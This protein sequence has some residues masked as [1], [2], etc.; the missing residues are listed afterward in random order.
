MPC[1]RSFAP[2][3]AFGLMF[4]L[5]G[6]SNGSPGAGIPSIGFHAQTRNAIKT[7]SA[8][9]KLVITG[10]PSVIAT[11]DGPKGLWTALPSGQT[12]FQISGT[13]YGVA[14][15][16]GSNNPEDADVYVFQG[17]IS[18]LKSVP[19]V[20]G[21][22]NGGTENF[23]VSFAPSSFCPNPH[24]VFA[25]YVGIDGIGF[26]D[27]TSC[28]GS[29][30]MF[31]AGPYFAETQDF[32]GVAADGEG[33]LMAVHLDPNVA[34]P[35]S[36]SIEFSGADAIGPDATVQY[37][38]VPA[39][40]QPFGL[41]V[42]FGSFEWWQLTL[43][44]TNSQTS[45]NYPTIAGGDV[46]KND[47][48]FAWSEAGVT[49]HGNADFLFAGAF[50]PNPPSVLTYQSPFNAQVTPAGSPQF[51]LNYFGYSKLKGGKTFYAIM[52]KWSTQNAI[53]IVT[54]AFLTAAGSTTYTFPNVTVSG[55]PPMVAQSN[56]TYTW[57]ASAV[58]APHAY[59]AILP[60]YQ[61]LVGE[62]NF[63]E[64]PSRPIDGV[65]PGVLDVA[66]A[67]NS[68]NVP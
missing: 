8:T 54:P 61:L 53:T 60:F 56:T 65:P 59:L 13:A 36:T 4:V 14:Y 40:V 63:N 2:V 1:P 30:Q 41:F 21:Q 49:G 17:T 48:Y 68:F 67:N 64:F 62:G 55:F 7:P 5:G 25:A 18:D 45:L 51:K 38:N 16:C 42:Q 20:C 9:V 66:S 29:P 58:H 34:V 52:G 46:G 43:G 3:T 10:V 12:S 28:G 22:F 50:S 11:Q 44:S 15:V 6:C 57:W 24:G 19:V 47:S 31:S 26:I 37:K 27:A 39:G 35:G 33:N 32:F 23:T